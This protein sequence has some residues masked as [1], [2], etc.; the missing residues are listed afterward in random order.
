MNAHE[1]R[2]KFINFFLSKGHVEIPSASIVPEN[3]PSVLFTTAGMQPLVPFLMGEEHPMGKRLVNAQK[4]VRTGDIDEVGDD[5]HHTFFEMLGNWSLGDYFKEDSI[6]WSHEFLTSPEWL[7]IPINKLAISVYAGDGDA[8]KDEYSAQLWKKLGVP[9]KRIAFLGKNDNW[10]PAG[11]ETKGPQGPDT[12][13]FYWVGEEEAPEVFDPADQRWVEIWNNVFMEYERPE[14]A[15]IPLKQKNVDTGMGLERTSAILQGKKS[16]YETELFQDIINQIAKM[17]DIPYTSNKKPF[18]IIADHIR[19][20]TFILADKADIQPANVDQGYI[21]RRLIRRAIR[22]AKMLNIHESF[23][24]PMVKTVVKI[25]QDA[26]PELKDRQERVQTLVA[27]EEK[28]FLLTISKGM[29]Q[30]EKVWTQKQHISGIDAFNLYATHGFP[31]ELTIELAEE[32]GQKIDTNVFRNEFQAHQETSRAGAQQKFAGG[33]AD[34]DPKTVMGHT[35]THLLHQALKTTLGD[36]VEQKGSNIT[37]RRLRF[38]FS[39]HEKLMPEQIQK[40][41]ALIN[42]QIKKD[43]PV[44]QKL[45]TVEEAKNFGAIGLFEDQ[46]AKR[47]D[48]IKVYMIG[49]DVLG[50]ASKEIC[51]GPHVTSTGKIQGFKIIKEESC[52]AGV[53]RIK[54]VVGSNN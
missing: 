5:T 42:D 34:D 20:T 50:F 8:P 33:L 7:N 22:Y 35:A 46:Y 40:V 24:V 51:G 44:T 37:A 11:G 52:S 43:L 31:L 4:C 27:N 26:Y 53:R 9:E 47:G 48:K 12:E 32:K 2:S 30:F 39:H 49:N 6:S 29:K 1:L 54:A 41:E 3:D 28:K 14:K 13:I 17:T 21:V 38:D 16:A 18:R 36:H 10:W 45:M 15:L 23:L 25:Y 19:A